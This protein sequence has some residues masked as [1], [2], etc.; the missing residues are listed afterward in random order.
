MTWRASERASVTFIK[1]DVEGA[2]LKA[3]YGAEKIIKANRPKLAICLYHKPEDII[4]IPEYIINLGLDY[5]LYIRHQSFC[6]GET[7][8]Y[9]APN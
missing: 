8:L 9:A 4:E 5:S 1:M 7:I 3:L 2:E 6:T